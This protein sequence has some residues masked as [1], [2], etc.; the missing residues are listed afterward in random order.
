MVRASTRFASFA[1]S[2]CPL[3]GFWGPGDDGVFQRVGRYS[4]MSLGDTFS[5]VALQRA[6]CCFV[7]QA[8]IVW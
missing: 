1:V 4:R 6:R 5:V 2:A 3:S 8:P 7:T